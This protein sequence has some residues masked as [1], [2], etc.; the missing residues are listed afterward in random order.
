[1][2]LAGRKE[3]VGFQVEKA[4]QG[5]WNICGGGTK[6][7]HFKNQPTNQTTTS[8]TRRYA[9]EHLRFG[10]QTPGQTRGRAA[11]RGAPKAGASKQ[12]RPEAHEQLGLDWASGGLVPGLTEWATPHRNTP[13][14]GSAARN[15]FTFCCT[16]CFFL[17][18]EAKPKPGP[19][20]AVAAGTVAGGTEEDAMV[21]LSGAPD[22]VENLSRRRSRLPTPEA[23]LTWAASRDRRL[24]RRRA[25]G[26]GGAGS[27]SWR[28]P[29]PNV[30]AVGGLTW[31]RG[32]ALG[33][34]VVCGPRA[35]SQVG[36][37]HRGDRDATWAGPL[38]SQGRSGWD[39]VAAK[40]PPADF[41]QFLGVVT[42]LSE[43]LLFTK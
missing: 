18:L 38:H 23:A 4:E 6:S 19:G 29:G 8:K 14:S 16:K 17:V 25:A 20:A 36:T 21:G 28:Q 9:G 13:T 12:G 40:S 32:R 22:R 2:D 5:W 24:A 43:A 41:A 39:S 10:G 42:S 26:R 15:T 31:R 3:R 11:A 27:A 33:S 30:R 35:V 37:S 34:R 1:M 7:P